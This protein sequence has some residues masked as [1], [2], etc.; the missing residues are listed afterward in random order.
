MTIVI[1]SLVQS[2]SLDEFHHIIFFCDAAAQIGP[3]P[4]RCSGF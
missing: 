3:R 1:C 2:L 4:S